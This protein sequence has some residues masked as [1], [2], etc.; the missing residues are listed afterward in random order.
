M[1]AIKFKTKSKNWN[2]F[3]VF[4]KWQKKSIFLIVVFFCSFFYL[5]VWHWKLFVTRTKR[6]ER[7]VGGERESHK[8]NQQF[9][10]IRPIYFDSHKMK[11]LTFF[12]T[13]SLAPH[14]SVCTRLEKMASAF[15]LMAMIITFSFL[16]FVGGGG[17]GG[18]GCACA[19][20]FFSFFFSINSNQ[21][22]FECLAPV[23]WKVSYGFVCLFQSNIIIIIIIGIRD[24]HII[25]MKT[26]YIE[27][28]TLRMCICLYD[29]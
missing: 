4:S 1:A 13:L 2:W 22:D 23:M 12:F 9:L 8:V 15:H 21:R 5:P 11:L 16:F 3:H 29:L 27:F 25:G 17:D 24:V 18:V 7:M 6:N 20:D 10:V 14:C 19:V 28:L 26:K